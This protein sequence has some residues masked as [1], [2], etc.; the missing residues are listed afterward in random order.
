M[1]V[2]ATVA[3]IAI[4]CITGLS[5]SATADPAPPKVGSAAPAASVE[6]VDIKQDPNALVR[7]QANAA[8]V[9]DGVNKLYPELVARAAKAQLDHDP[10]KWLCLT[11]VVSQLNAVRQNI[12]NRQHMLSADAIVVQGGTQAGSRADR[13]ADLEKALQDYNMIAEYDQQAK[14]LEAAANACIGVDMTYIGQDTVTME[15]NPNVPPDVDLPDPN[16]GW[17]DG[18]F[19]PPVCVSCTQ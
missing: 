14:K 17:G 15:N 12:V 2:R 11:N 1:R 6:E 5:G 8:K 7:M 13:I 18:W 10:V 19:Q 9:A 3:V 16:G 4:A